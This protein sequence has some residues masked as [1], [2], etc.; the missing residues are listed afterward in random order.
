[1]LTGLKKAFAGALTGVAVAVL[2]AAVLAVAVSGRGAAG[3]EK[4][5]W[6]VL[7]AAA[8]TAGLVT[9]RKIG[10]GGAVWGAVSGLMLFAAVLLTGLGLCKTVDLSALYKALTCVLGAAVSGVAAV[11]L[12]TGRRVGHRARLRRRHG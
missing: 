12:K 6:A 2:T 1:L 5:S 7:I 4:I 3:A 11:N 9:G 10:S 8:L